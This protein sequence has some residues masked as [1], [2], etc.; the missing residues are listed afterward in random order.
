MAALSLPS[1]VVPRLFSFRLP[2]GFT[3]RLNCMTRLKPYLM[4]SRA[5]FLIS[6]GPVNSSE[7]PSYIPPHTSTVA[8]S[9]ASIGLLF[10]RSVLVFTQIFVAGVQWGAASLVAWQ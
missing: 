9:S 1:S 7:V 10:F 8:F 2:I 5:T 4:Y 3:H 6:V